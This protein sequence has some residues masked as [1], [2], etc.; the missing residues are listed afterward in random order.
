M[1]RTGTRI[2]WVPPLATLAAGIAMRD[3]VLVAAAGPLAL[4]AFLA[5]MDEDAPMDAFRAAIRSAVAGSAS[6]LAA[7]ALAAMALAAVHGFWQPVHEWPL[8]DAGL[9]AI[10]LATFVLY[11]LGDEAALLSVRQWIVRWAALAAGVVAAA[12]ARDAE[13]SACALPLAIATLMA[14]AGWRLLREVA[15]EF[16][17]IGRER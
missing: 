15:S 13:W 3:C 11:A 2:R 5:G 6:I 4:Y 1:S 14:L 8:A 12:S 7:I 9:L 10:S 17:A 16:L